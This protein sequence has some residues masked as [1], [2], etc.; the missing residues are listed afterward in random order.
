MTNARVFASRL[1][2]LLRREQV[3]MAEFLVALSDFDF[4][5]DETA[6]P[7]V[8]VPALPFHPDEMPVARRA[9]SEP[10]TGSLS[11]LHITVSNGFLKKL[12][13]ARDALSHALPGANTE[14][15]LEAG[16]DLL[17]KQHARPTPRAL[18][19][20]S[21]ADNMRLL[22]R[23][24]NDMAARKTFGD[25]WMNQFTANPKNPRAAPLT[26]GLPSG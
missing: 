13:A 2:G 11:R 12:D 24:H 1:A 4:H 10:L 3:A 14:A 26:Q 18:G 19:G 6:H 21:T 15:V 20:L 22:C 16:L 9:S 8:A 17:L 5:P 25:H 23:F 7:P